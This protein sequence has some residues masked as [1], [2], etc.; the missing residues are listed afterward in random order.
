[1]DDEFWAELQQFY[2]EGEIIDL[3]AAIGAIQLLQPLQG[4]APHGADHVGKVV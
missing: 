4:W 2:D 3:L 1:V